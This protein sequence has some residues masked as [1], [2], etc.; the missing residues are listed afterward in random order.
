MTAAFSVTLSAILHQLP[1][2]LYK[3]KLLI[4]KAIVRDLKDLLA[5]GSGFEKTTAGKRSQDTRSYM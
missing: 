1:K 5:T 3:D 4:W 2:Y